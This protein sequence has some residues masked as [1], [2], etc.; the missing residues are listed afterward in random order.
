MKERDISK[1][2]EESKKREKM[3]AMD[4]ITKTRLQVDHQCQKSRR[5][6]EPNRRN[7]SHSGLFP[8]RHL[9]NMEEQC[10]TAWTL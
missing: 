3:T 7:F 2:E 5:L 8:P 9:R 10:V 6:N 1:H 4:R